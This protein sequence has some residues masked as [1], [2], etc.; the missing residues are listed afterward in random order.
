MRKYH[1]ATLAFERTE[2]DN[3][4]FS[5]KGSL[6]KDVICHNDIA[7]YREIEFIKEHTREWL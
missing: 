6:E 7:P 3:W 1:D 4:M 2:K 5:Y